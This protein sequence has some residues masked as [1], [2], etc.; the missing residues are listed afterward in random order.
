MTKMV[1]K[2]FTLNKYHTESQEESKPSWLCIKCKTFYGYS[3]IDDI[4]VFMK[5]QST[6]VIAQ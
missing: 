4:H 1:S 6:G 3:F 5:S 2:L